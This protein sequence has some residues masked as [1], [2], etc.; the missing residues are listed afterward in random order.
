MLLYFNI[1]YYYR[2]FTL[3]RLNRVKVKYVNLDN[4]ILL[5]FIFFYI[6]QKSNYYLEKKKVKQVWKSENKQNRFGENYINI[7]RV[8][9]LYCKKLEKKYNSLN[10]IKDIKLIIIQKLFIISLNFY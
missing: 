10:A 7:K 9:K 1:L 5:I 8:K 6:L 3:F 2:V 4:L